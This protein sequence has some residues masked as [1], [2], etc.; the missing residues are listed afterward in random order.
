MAGTGTAHLRPESE[1]LL[2]VEAEIAQRM[3]ADGDH[4]LL[5]SLEGAGARTAQHPE[6]ERH[7]RL[8]V[9]VAV[10]P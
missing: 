1:V 7:G 3:T 4:R 10:P 8:S 2:R 6:L 9:G 5:E